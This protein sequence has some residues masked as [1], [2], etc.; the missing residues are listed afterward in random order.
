MGHLLCRNAAYDA[1][2]GARGLRSPTSRV[3]A[4]IPPQ[5]AQHRHGP[6]TPNIAVIGLFHIESRFFL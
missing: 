5:P 3:I 4:D 2:L 1:Y 6:G